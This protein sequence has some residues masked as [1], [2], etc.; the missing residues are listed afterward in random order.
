[1][2]NSGNN[3]VPLHAMAFVDDA[4]HEHAPNPTAANSQKPVLQVTSWQR[5]ML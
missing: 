5:T 4:S 3:A 1:L 2:Q